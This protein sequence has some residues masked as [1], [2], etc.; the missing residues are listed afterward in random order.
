MA[1]V[2]SFTILAKL[3]SDLV[4]NM[5]S[6]AINYFSWF[7]V[8][9]LTI[10]TL[11]PRLHHATLEELKEEI[12]RGDSTDTRVRDRSQKEEVMTR[13]FKK[14][15]SFDFGVTYTGQEGLPV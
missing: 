7:L 4:R 3:Y 12:E 15:F 2:T 6:L 14:A 9:V 11:V 5:T 8:L 13:Q 10:Y 1:E